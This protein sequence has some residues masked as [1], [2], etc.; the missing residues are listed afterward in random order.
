MYTGFL[1][2]LEHLK[3]KR[4]VCYESRKREIEKRRK[5]EDLCDER[6]KLKGMNLHASHALDGCL[7]IMNPELYILLIDKAESESRQR[8]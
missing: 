5:N 7:F 8:S 3:S 6:L 1:E 2:E 4:I